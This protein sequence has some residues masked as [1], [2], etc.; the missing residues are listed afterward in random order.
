MR[1][2]VSTISGETHQIQTIS[3]SC[4]WHQHMR[5]IEL[6]LIVRPA[7][8]L[9]NAHVLHFPFYILTSEL[10]SKSTYNFF[11]CPNCFNGRIVSNC[12]STTMRINQYSQAVSG[13]A[14]SIKW[15]EPLVSMWHFCVGWVSLLLE[16]LKTG[17]TTTLMLP[18]VALENRKSIS[19]PPKSAMETGTWW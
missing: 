1:D 7:S 14:K 19:V 10:W 12:C 11:G 4:S 13:Q 3:G 15:K 8:I 2:H 6:K 16:N 18:S 17:A 5:S 9:F